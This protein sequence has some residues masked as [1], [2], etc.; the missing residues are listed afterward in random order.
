MKDSLKILKEIYKNLA[1]IGTHTLIFLVC[2]LLISYTQNFG[3]V[4]ATLTYELTSSEKINL[5]KKI[6][7][8]FYTD[9]ISSGI[10]LLYVVTAFLL[11][12]NFILVG[13]YFKKRRTFTGIKKL[14]LSGVLALFGVGCAAC[15]GLLL[16]TIVNI[17]GAT[18]LI[19]F[20]PFGGSEF[21]VLAIALLTYSVI[22][23]S[24]KINEPFVC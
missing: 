8:Y 23:I 1:F 5:I 7:L 15:G 20:L 4:H 18:S 24:K 19:V 22:S 6:L 10:F 14:S 9:N 16:S 12:Y 17:A 11:S 13:Y 2:L 3:Q 21:L